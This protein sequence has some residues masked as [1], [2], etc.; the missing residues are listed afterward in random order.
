MA[1]IMTRKILTAIIALLG[2]SAAAYGQ[3]AAPKRQV[4]HGVVTSW[5]HVDNRRCA[6]VQMA[7]GKWYSTRIILALDGFATLQA[8]GDSKRHKT[9]MAFTVLQPIS[10]C[11]PLPGIKVWVGASSRGRHR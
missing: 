9:L 2:F 4:S 6:Y 10:E 1:L 8:I 3:S 11:G 5:E 7:G